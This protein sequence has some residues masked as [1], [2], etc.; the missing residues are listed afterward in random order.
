MI[1]RPLH[2]R[3]LAQRLVEADKTSGGLFIPD[4]AK[5]KPMEAR[6][7]AVGTG[8]RLDNGTVVPL[9]VQAGDKILLAKYTGSEIKL[10]GKDHLILREDDV[11]AVLEG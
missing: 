2:D 1:I 9:S 3:I 5:E 4:N 6:V 10:E 11:L 7:I 8:K